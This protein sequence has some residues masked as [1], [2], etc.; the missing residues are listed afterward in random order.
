MVIEEILVNIINL[1]DNVDVI[2]VIVK[3]KDE[4]ILVSVK[5]SG[6]EYN[7]II[8]QDNLKFDNISV[9]NKIADN[10]D[11]SRVLGLNSTV[12]V[13]RHSIMKILPFYFK[14]KNLKKK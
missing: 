2:D 1:N 6:I 13:S 7:P 9:L 14:I 10:I 8:K 5:D 11:Y 3:I 4:H 12:I